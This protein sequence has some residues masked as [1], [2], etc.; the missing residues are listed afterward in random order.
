MKTLIWLTLALLPGSALADDMLIYRCTSSSDIP[1]IQRTPCPEGSRQQIQRVPDPARSAPAV[2]TAP[3]QV[4][5]EA[6]V[7]PPVAATSA[8]VPVPVPALEAGSPRA[9]EER[10]VMEARMVDAPGGDSILDSALLPRRGEPSVVDGN[11][12]PKPPLPAI[13]QCINADGGQYLHEYEPAPGRCELL[14]VA[15]IGGGATPVN[16]ASCEMV[17][18]RCSEA[19]E[20]QRCGNWQQRLRDARGRERF[21][22]PDNRDAMRADRE[23]IQAV[24]EASDCAVPE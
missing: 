2:S 5:M 14:N 21:A 23:R 19:A 16:A 13:F 1:T 22:A 3:A 15:G 18:D 12:P 10:P 9:G 17:S 6:A 20:S 7:P 4:P 8:F 11:A 24:L